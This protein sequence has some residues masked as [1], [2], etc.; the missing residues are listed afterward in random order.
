LREK[1]LDRTT[2]KTHSGRGSEPVVRQTTEL[3]KNN[4]KAS[5]RTTEAGGSLEPL[6]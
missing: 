4:N 5:G 6:K 2:W 1:P 3:L